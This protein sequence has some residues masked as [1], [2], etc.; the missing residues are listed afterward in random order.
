MNSEHVTR[1]ILWSMPH[2][3]MYL[4]WVFFVI[5]LVVFFVGLKQ[6]VDFIT[7]GKGFSALKDLLPENL[8]WGRFFQTLLLQGKLARKK[9]VGTFHGGIFFGFLILTV[10]T[11]VV[12]IDLDTPLRIFYGNTYKILSL[13]ADLA[14]FFIL[15]GMGMAIYRRF[16]S[17]PS[18]LASENN[19]SEIAMYLVIANFIIIGFF[20]EAVRIYATGMPAFEAI[21]SP[22][23]FILA[24]VVAMVSPSA[25]F[26]KIPYQVAWYF[27]MLSTMFFIALIPYTKFFHMMLAPLSALVTTPRTGGI[28]LPMDFEDEDA[29]TFGLGKVSELTLRN[30]LNLVA[31]VECGRCSEVCPALASGKLLDPKK[32]ITKT[33]DFAALGNDKD[34]WEDNI[35]Q[36]NELDACTTCGACMEECP[37]E[38]QH[39]TLIQEAK[40]YKVLTLGEIPAAAGDAVNKIKT[41]G[42]PWGISQDD[43]FKW[44]EGMDVPVIEADKKVDYLYYVGCAGSYDPS[45]QKVTKDTINLL[46]KAGV[47]FAVMGKNEKCNGDPIRRFGD[48][49]SFFEVALE[50]IATINQYKF[51][52]IIVQCPHCLHTI[53][54]EYAKFD[55]GEYDVVH[56][57]EL[58]ADLLTS[59]KLKPTITTMA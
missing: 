59:G 55:D 20:L 8:Q 28:L 56:H 19:T 16:I 10:V 12:G 36:S 27:H 41:Q 46:K 49:Y 50:N 11:T 22:V 35:F 26:W 57:T 39:V 45:N 24:K 44:A 33:R 40:R 47:D 52:K 25:E 7:N 38:I 2:W 15:F 6:R 18:H 17:K 53:G 23:G 13:L 58:L 32:I 14:G 42:N 5:A 1:E 29:E 4:T 31:C 21:Y 3:S 43:R 48:E 9:L 30:R 51:D 34:F 37:M 54:K